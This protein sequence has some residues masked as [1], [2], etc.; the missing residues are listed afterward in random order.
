MIATPNGFRL[1]ILMG[2]GV[3]PSTV[4]CGLRAFIQRVSCLQCYRDAVSMDK[5]LKFAG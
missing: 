3:K 1:D 4:G 2:F 5:A